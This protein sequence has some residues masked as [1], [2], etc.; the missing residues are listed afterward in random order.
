MMRRKNAEGGVGTGG[1]RT[2][3]ISRR[4]RS[5]STLCN[6]C[7]SLGRVSVASAN[8]CAFCFLGPMTSSVNVFALKS[9]RA[10]VFSAL[11]LLWSV[12]LFDQD[13]NTPSAPTLLTHG[14]RGLPFSGP[15]ACTVRVE[16]WRLLRAIAAV[17]TDRIE[18]CSPS[19]VAVVEE[20][21]L[22]WL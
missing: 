18:L 1:G 16:E 20:E 22:H 19:V 8:V 4:T 21:Q 7:G 11:F 2:R 13:K 3:A 10:F 9:S 6:S 5:A 12:R 17:G 14:E 15:Y